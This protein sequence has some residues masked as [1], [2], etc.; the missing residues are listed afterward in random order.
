VGLL[1]SFIVVW[2]LAPDEAPNKPITS[3]SHRKQLRML[4]VIFV[5]LAA[6]LQCGLLVVLPLEKSAAPVLAIEAGLL[7]Q[8]FSLTKTG[9]NFIDS[10]DNVFLMKGGGKGEKVK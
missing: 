3:L 4:S 6:I 1:V 9:H 8:V 10:I 5:I 7:W 2:R